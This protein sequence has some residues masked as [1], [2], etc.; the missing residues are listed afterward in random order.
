MDSLIER[1]KKY[2]ELDAKRS[3]GEWRLVCPS[4]P[5]NDTKPKCWYV[6]KPYWGAICVPD[7][8]SPQWPIQ[9]HNMAFIA[10]A[11]DMLTDLQATVRALEVARE[12]LG[13]ITANKHMIENGAMW[14][15]LSPVAACK[16]FVALADETLGLI[17]QTLGKAGV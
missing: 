10:S 14:A 17:N 3:D 2:A 1:M 15:V 13:L 12:R 7:M 6:I 9:E 5:N 11:P 8:K 16:E 4:H